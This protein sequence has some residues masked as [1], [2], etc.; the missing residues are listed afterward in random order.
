MF[1]NLFEGITDFAD[2]L[3]DTGSIVLAI[4]FAVIALLIK[5]VISANNSPTA[6]KPD[7]EQIEK[8][9]EEDLKENGY[10]SRDH[11]V[12]Y[13]LNAYRVCVRCERDDLIT[14]ELLW[15]AGLTFLLASAFSI[16]YLGV[17]AYVLYALLIVK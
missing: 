13:P 12:N 7:T 1:K 16:I 11:I 3:K 14:F 15:R 4:V 6:A 8:M 17:I 5:N 2:L 9:I 10:F